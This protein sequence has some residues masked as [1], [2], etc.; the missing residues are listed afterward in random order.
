MPLD[1]RLTLATSPT[2]LFRSELIPESHRATVSNWFR[3][4]KLPMNLMTCA[5]LLA[6]NN[7]A[8]AADKR[9]IFSVCTLA[10]VVG[11]YIARGRQISAVQDVL[12]EE[13]II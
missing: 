8:V 13:G 2:S 5:A 9:L 10:L 6:I 3:V 7:A 4:P 1:Y 12:T 11:T